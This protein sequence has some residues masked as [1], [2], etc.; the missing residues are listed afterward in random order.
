MRKL[1]IVAGLAAAML[2]LVG[3]GTAAGE[4][5]PTSDGRTLSTLDQPK[6]DW[7]TSDLEA[8]ILAAGPQGV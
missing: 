5:T 1:L 6:P 3:A 4:S 8:Q 7:L 2:L